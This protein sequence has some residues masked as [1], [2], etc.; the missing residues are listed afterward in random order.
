M[1]QEKQKKKKSK[2]KSFSLIAIMFLLIVWLVYGNVSLQTTV[3]EVPVS[4]DY[5]DM[6]GFTIAVDGGWLAR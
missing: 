4:T 2:V 6:N 5:S 3:Y 1:K